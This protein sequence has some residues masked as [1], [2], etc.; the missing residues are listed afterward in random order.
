MPLRN[1]SRDSLCG[2]AEGSEGVR[3]YAA[4]VWGRG[5]LVRA[6]RITLR[7]KPCCRGYQ[8]CA[9]EG[10]SCGTEVMVNGKGESLKRN[11]RRYFD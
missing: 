8:R 4:F 1:P 5:G 11:F 3:G 6:L 10:L 9:L 7:H 2:G